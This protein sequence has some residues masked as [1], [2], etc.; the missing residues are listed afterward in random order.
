MRGRWTSHRGASRPQ[1]RLKTGGPSVG[2]ARKKSGSG[3]RGGT[4][5]SRSGRS[6][7]AAFARPR[8]LLSVMMALIV[9]GAVWALAQRTPVTKPIVAAAPKGAKSTADDKMPLSWKNLPRQMA[10]YGQRR[11][12]AA[13]AGLKSGRAGT[14]GSGQAEVRRFPLT[15]EDLTP[16]TLSDER[17]PSLRI[18][19][20]TIAFSSNGIDANNDGFL[21][22]SAPGS[23]PYHIFILNPSTR[24][25]R[26]ITGFGINRAGA[27]NRNQRQPT[28]SPDGNRICFV[29]V[30]SAAT[31]QLALV[32]VNVNSTVN[33][34]STAITNTRGRKLDPAWNPGGDAI[35]FA[36]N[37]AFIGSNLVVDAG[38][39]DIFTIDPFGNTLSV[40][41]LTGDADGRQ[42]VATSQRDP[43]DL[44]GNT[45]DDRHPSYSQVN[46]GV[47]FFSSNR[48]TALS[49]S[50]TTTTG[51][52]VRL[53]V[54]RRIFAMSAGT[55]QNKRQITNPIT[56]GGAE[57]DEDDYPTASRAGRVSRGTLVS[58]FRERL[59]FHTNSRIDAQDSVRDRNVWS[60]PIATQGAAILNN[61]LG[62]VPAFEGSTQAGGNVAQVESS[63]LSTSTATNAF[64]G[65]T[66]DRSADEEPAYSRIRT[67]SDLSNNFPTIV[68]ASQRSASTR[69]GSALP[70]GTQAPPAVINP[71]GGAVATS[72]HDL[73]TTTSADFTPPL[74][75][76]YG[77]GSQRSAFVAPGVQAPF[78][79]PRTPEEGLGQNSKLIVGV[80]LSDLESGLN[81]GSLVSPT[82]VVTS[83]PVPTATPIPTS[84]PGA[85]ATSTPDPNITS[86]PAPAPIVPAPAP[87]FGGNSVSV[88]IR[89]SNPTF[90][91][92]FTTQPNE[93]IAIVPAVELE[94]PFVTG[95]IALD[96][97]DDGPAPPLGNGHE[98]Q[99]DAVRGD[100]Q[101]YAQVSIDLSQELAGQEQGDFIF[102]LSVT[103]RAGNAFTYDKIFGFST[104]LFNTPSGLLFVSDYTLGQ[105]FP[106]EL[107]GGPKDSRI[108][109]RSTGVEYL[110]LPP[111][112]SYHLSNPGADA[113]DIL[114]GFRLNGPA[115]L[116]TFS[117]PGSP[118]FGLSPTSV[119]V[120]RVL[121]RGPVTQAVLDAYRP[122][123][124][125]QID[126]RAPGYE[127]VEAVVNPTAT[128]LV[129]PTTLPTPTL[130][131][132]PGGTAEPLPTIPVTVAERAIIWASPYTEDVLS[133]PG[134]I[135]DTN[136]QDLL[137]NFL[138]NGGRLFLNGQD[139][140]YALSQEGSVT[141][142]FLR[143]EL[144]ASYR[145]GGT[146]GETATSP[147]DVSNSDSYY[148]FAINGSGGNPISNR[149]PGFN[150]PRDPPNTLHVPFNPLPQP[151]QPD[152]YWDAADNDNFADIISPVPAND[153]ETVTE[154]YTYGNVGRAGQI[155]E[156]TGRA[157][158][159][160]SAVVFFGFGLEHINREY[161]NNPP[162][163]RCRNFRSKVA[164]NIAN[165]LR[166]GNITGQ[167]TNRSGAPIPNFLVQLTDRELNTRFALVRTDQN[168]FYRFTGVP[169]RDGFYRVS[170][171]SQRLRTGRDRSLNPGY[172][173][174]PNVLPTLTVIGG[175]TNANNNF[176]V[177]EVLPSTVTGR[178]ISDRGTS[179]D[180]DDDD[181]PFVDVASQLPVLIRS[182]DTNIA[183]SPGF[184][185]G[186]TYAQLVQTDAFGNFAFSNVPADLRVE[187]VFNPRPGLTSQGGDIPDG[188]G[189]DYNTPT[190]LIQR[191][192]NFGRRVIPT[193]NGYSGPRVPSIPETG[194][195]F[196]P[197]SD[198][199]RLGDVPVPPAGV[200]ISGRILRTQTTGGVT[201]TVAAAGA[202][203][204]L[205][206]N[207]LV[208]QQVT[209]NQQGQYTFAD[210][211]PGTYTIRA[212]LVVGISN[213]SGSTAIQVA[214]APGVTNIVARDITV[215]P[216]GV[217]PG[218][219]PTPTRTP[220]PTPT[221]APVNETYQPG[222]D[223]L[224]SIPYA[225]SSAP[226]AVTTVAR[227][228]TLPPVSGG[229]LNYQL[230]R[231]NPLTNA[232]VPLGATSPVRRGEGYFLR[233]R[234]RAVSLRRPP[235]DRTRFPTGVTQFTITLRRSPS[236]RTRNG[237]F[238]LIGFPFNPTAFTRVNWAES[239]FIG[240]DG[241]TYPNV[242]AAIGA[243][244]LPAEMEQIFTLE[245]GATQQTKTGVL[246]PFRGYFVQTAVD[247]VRVVLRARL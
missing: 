60:L 142:A 37:T 241:R 85:G 66:Q 243:G 24:R 131:P 184:P 87:P 123:A 235:A 95:N 148:G 216:G 45:V 99:A 212:T 198:V 76:P 15:E 68:F 86:T 168:G 27:A 156:R 145:S 117:P 135:S 91:Q 47:L 112:E 153:G 12:L 197:Q 170:P 130:G 33:Q 120:Y 94:P 100:G 10:A 17:E 78:S 121:S 202:T 79:A 96:V 111:V 119:D 106:Y 201:S 210:V 70:G 144:K 231:Y 29:D 196:V 21:D 195:L 167:I 104:Q 203:V 185:L 88:R 218:A 19:D 154:V 62:S 89:S 194:A 193:D 224:I 23:R 179:T 239:I 110:N 246:V 9:V 77:T 64:F 118:S 209:A 245:P 41:R 139:V 162:L 11:R 122:S 149:D 204:Q 13:L 236:D 105:R 151:P 226:A 34:A 101:Y 213:L 52:T 115:D 188:S 225:D 150:V 81:T 215:F 160:Q 141:N 180:V 223:Y 116:T 125:S 114:P 161:T 230:F 206:L 220:A 108:G 189:I 138:D 173:F 165:L 31:T 143:D 14:R 71:G 232:Y 124:A 126:P 247:N 26:Q 49:I 172:F 163:S 4:E 127:L 25:V 16:R 48:Q 90:D 63:L 164:E 84:G 157:G 211:Q 133:S 152:T 53:A 238:N 214:V 205:Q 128:P 166:T 35:A 244:L 240:P 65:A 109:I 20:G 136:I 190:A 171:A 229:V 182:V 134:T 140:I 174:N 73:F 82:P 103:D 92:R 50:G 175:Q 191:N 207:G 56:R 219:T 7:R 222:Q 181:D 169:S 1:S 107:V 147:L 6:P 67:T 155:I 69:P 192:P 113:V 80:V 42:G 32:S 74:L 242:R 237:G 146:G 177:N 200:S 8:V 5:P 217:N 233:P 159:L 97:Y 43:Q 18:Q 83:A 59:A 30:E 178:A 54:G 61:S 221:T 51:T 22:A 40:R 227:A 3:R 132:T 187:I 199:L 58:P 98:R 137:T 39:F 2:G 183:P 176:R 234:A 46:P 186:G 36:S 228:F 102:D 38:S 208:V 129:P 75:V 72:T 93:G 28:W 57:T 44:V 158:G 55:G